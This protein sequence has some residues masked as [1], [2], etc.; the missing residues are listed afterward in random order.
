MYPL[1]PS[2]PAPPHPIIYQEMEAQ[3]IGAVLRHPAAGGQVYSCLE[4]F[5]SLALEAQL[6]PITRTV[7][8][9]QLHITPTFKWK[10]R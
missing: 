6:H 8:R 3:E 2:Y 5:P 9:I 10:D 4:A 1:T 7:L